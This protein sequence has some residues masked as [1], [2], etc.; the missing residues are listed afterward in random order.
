MTTHYEAA[1]QEA[2]EADEAARLAAEDARVAEAVRT[3]RTA[4]IFCRVID[5]FGDAG[6]CFRL[7]RRFA[8]LGLSVR[9]VIDRPD[10]LA[11][12]VPELDPAAESS[13]A[14]GIEVRAWDAFAADAAPQ[15]AGLVVETF[16]CRIPEP[17]EKALAAEV[18]AAKA[19]G[20]PARF[21]YFNLDYLSAE[22]WVEDFHNVWGLHP[23]LPIRKLWFFPGFTEKTGGVVIEDGYL[24]AEA[25]FKD[26]ERDAL[27]KSLGADPQALALFFFAYPSNPVEA[28]AQGAALYGEPVSILAAPGEAGDKLEAAVKALGA[29]AS[30][31][32]VIRPGFFPQRD[33]DRALWACDAAVIRGE[34]SFVRAQL[35]GLPIIWS[36]YPTA[37]KGHLVKLEAWLERIGPF[38]RPGSLKDDFVRANRRWVEGSI[39]AGDVSRFLAA[40]PEFWSGARNWRR[41]LFAR[42]DLARRMLLRAAEGDEID[43]AKK[44]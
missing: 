31:V 4:D 34:D 28:L 22:K 41:G 15:T 9:L 42:G 18:E 24:E 11:K 38:F 16:A 39:S 26:S 7:A 44:P 12:L 2:D 1:G 43:A 27:L 35:A 17:Y 5:N 19:E 25:R 37:D 23:T 3:Y 20:R 13:L 29:A 32:R 14:E 36:T 30:N 33:F 8:S 6:V 21:F 40:V 10:V